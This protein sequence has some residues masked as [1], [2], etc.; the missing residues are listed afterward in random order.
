MAARTARVVECP[1]E[2]LALLA[3]AENLKPPPSSKQLATFAATYLDDKSLSRDESTSTRTWWDEFLSITKAKTVTDLNRDS[4]KRYRKTIKD[5]QGDH[6]NAWVRSRFGK[7][8]T[9]INHALVE[10]ELTEREKLILSDVALLKKPSKPTPKPCDSSPKKMKAILSKADKWDSAL[11]LLALN[12]AYTNIDCAALRW[13]MVDFENGTIRFDRGKS[14]HL[15]TQSLP[16]ICSL[17][18]RTIKALRALKNGHTNVFVSSRGEPPHRNTI[19]RR[20]DRCCTQAGV[21][22]RTF[23]HLRKSAM[24]AASN[25]PKVPDR[26]IELLAGHSSGIKEHYVVRK[27]VQLACEAIER[28]YFGGKK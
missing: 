2:P 5:R 8:K 16:R 22:N 3:N 7:I 19:T 20:F 12:A 10:I 18:G 21:E 24:T 1:A 14:V 9:I 15:T 6:S 28:Y 17:W 27:N 25:D 4:F 11:I 23:K 26:Q 13:D